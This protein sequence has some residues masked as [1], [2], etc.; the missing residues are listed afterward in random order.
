MQERR[1]SIANSLLTHVFRALTHRYSVRMSVWEACVFP[2]IMCSLPSVP[3]LD[4]IWPWGRIGWVMTSWWRHQIETFPALLA[5]GRGIHRWPVDSP[6]KG[7]WCGALMYSLIGTWINGWAI[8]RDAGNLKR[9]RTYY[10]VTVMIQQII[11]DVI[12]YRYHDITQYT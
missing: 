11:M 9:H 2:L 8:D 5:L 3:W 12:A 1:N 4:K 7:Q 10:D 6:H